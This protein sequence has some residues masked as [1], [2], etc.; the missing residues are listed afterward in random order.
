[1][2]H[3]TQCRA[4]IDAPHTVEPHARL[5]SYGELKMYAKFNSTTYECAD[6]HTNFERREAMPHGPV[7]WRRIDSWRLR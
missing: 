7:T 2:D 5:R 4:L 3:C 6:C 1:M